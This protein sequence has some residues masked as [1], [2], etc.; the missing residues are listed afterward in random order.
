[1][2]RL[3]AV[4]VLICERG[5]RWRDAVRRFWGPF[6]HVPAE[7]ASRSGEGFV[8]QTISVERQKLRSAVASQA[9]SCVVVWEDQASEFAGIAEAIFQIHLSHPH[10]TQ[11]V[12]CRRAGDAATR[13]RLLMFQE[14]GVELVIPS[15][16]QMPRYRNFVNQAVQRHRF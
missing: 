16:E 5:V 2:I 6:Q 8:F 7:E 9:Q 14:L 10:A 12:A 3:R 13:E 11:C 15:P 4:P 1:M